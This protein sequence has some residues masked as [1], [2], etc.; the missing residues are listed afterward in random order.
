MV[1]I[2]I[3]TWCI[4]TFVVWLYLDPRMIRVR[5]QPFLLEFE[6]KNPF[7]FLFIFQN[8]KEIISGKI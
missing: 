5:I 8:T 2:P 1:K 6:K 4:H 3:T 7:I